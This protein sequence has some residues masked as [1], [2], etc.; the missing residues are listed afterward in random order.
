[1][2]PNS[3]KAYQKIFEGL[4][5]REFLLE[6]FLLD[7]FNDAKA[8]SKPSELIQTKFKMAFLRSIGDNF[9]C[10]FPGQDPYKSYCRSALCNAVLGSWAWAFT[11]LKKASKV[12][13]DFAYHNYLYGLVYAAIGKF[14]SALPKLEVAYKN[15]PHNDA[16]QRISEALHLIKSYKETNQ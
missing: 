3:E 6:T 7:E 1:M 8:V 14:G 9:A 15:E 16:K 2:I 10:I 5:L 12:S 13:N 4:I 11:A